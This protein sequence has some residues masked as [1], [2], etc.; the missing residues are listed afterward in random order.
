MN[1]VRSDR[2]LE[3]VSA[4]YG[5]AIEPERIDD[6][7]EAW[8]RWC[9]EFLDA[10]EDDFQT[11]SPKFDD[12]LLASERLD[13]KHPQATAL[14]TTQAPLIVLDA[15]NKVVAANAAA[16]GMIAR[17]DVDTE[18]LIGS[19]RTAKRS[20][21]DDEISAYR[22]QGSK[23]GQSYLTVEVSATAAIRAQ[24]PSAET[25]IMLSL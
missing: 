23:G 16:S 15:K 9:E 5:A 11:I 20:L 3:L 21:S 22:C 13:D 14:E 8:D 19:R 24:I 12:A 1:V 10:G 6:L 17:G 25:M 4:A 18:H 7:Q 2:V